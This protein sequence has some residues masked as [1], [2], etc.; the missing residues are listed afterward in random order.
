MVWVYD[1]TQS[2]LVAMLMHASFAG[3]LL[4]VMPVGMSGAPFL[5]WY[6]AVAV[7][8]WIVV[9]GVAV[10]N[11]GHLARQPLRMWAA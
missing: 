6:L 4:A 11:G 7:A 2:L 5:T 9:A 10:A 8:V 3:C 1:H